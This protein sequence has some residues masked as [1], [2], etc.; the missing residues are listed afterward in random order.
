LNIITELVGFL[1]PLAEIVCEDLMVT[2]WGSILPL[3]S[4]DFALLEFQ[5]WNYGE[6][7]VSSVEISCI[8][9]LK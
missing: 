7:V 3:V 6:Q 2:F 8:D 1:L 9:H 5:L 4:S